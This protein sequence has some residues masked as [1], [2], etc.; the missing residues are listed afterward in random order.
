MLVKLAQSNSP[1]VGGIKGVA[2]SPGCNAP[3]AVS[4]SLFDIVHTPLA[5]TTKLKVAVKGRERAG[6]TAGVRRAG[7]FETVRPLFS[8]VRFDTKCILHISH[9]FIILPHFTNN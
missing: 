8:Y 7:A 5:C 9:L 3:W 2:G 6:D 4:M 1:G